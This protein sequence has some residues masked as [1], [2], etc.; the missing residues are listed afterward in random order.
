MIVP[1]QPV[2]RASHLRRWLTL[3]AVGLFVAA[4]LGTAPPTSAYSWGPWSPYVWVS[5][6]TSAE[7]VMSTYVFNH[8]AGPFRDPGIGC[9]HKVRYRKA[10]AIAGA[11]APWVDIP[12]Q[13]QDE[14]NFSIYGMTLTT[15]VR[16]NG[17]VAVA[18]TPTCGYH[19]YIMA[20][21]QTRCNVVGS[22]TSLVT[23]QLDYEVSLTVQGFGFYR[24]RGA[25]Q[26]VSGSGWINAPTYYHG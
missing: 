19:S 21:K 8:Y 16:H 10:A 9:R 5:N 1:T 12:I 18:S 3:L 13:L 20:L 15:V 11:P 26:T 7:C 24:T 14:G 2:P 17:S 22:W 6:Q 23:L 4:E 25:Q